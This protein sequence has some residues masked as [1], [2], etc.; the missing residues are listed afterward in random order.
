MASA[1]GRIDFHTNFFLF[2]A[3]IIIHCIFQQQLKEEMSG[4]KPTA[5]Y[6]DS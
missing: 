6:P 3:S 2:A 4:K 1:W 5:F